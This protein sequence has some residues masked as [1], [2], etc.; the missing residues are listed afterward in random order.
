MFKRRSSFDINGQML[1]S[2]KILNNDIKGDKNT[3]LKY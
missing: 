3:L 2:F 1:F